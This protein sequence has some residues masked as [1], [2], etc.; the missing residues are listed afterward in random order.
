MENNSP[1]SSWLRKF[2]NA[3]R[4]IAVGVRGGRTNS[5]LVH[6]PLAIAAIV[7]GLILGVSKQEL[8]ILLLCVGIVMAA[9]LFNCSI[10][11]LARSITNQPD[12]NIRNALDIASG[13][14][15]FASLIAAIVGAVVL[16]TAAVN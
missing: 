11:Y 4:G 15:L 7:A 10:E 2:Q 14:V 3:F 12:E 16:I 9:E 6:F 1:N 5:F 13:A 8:M